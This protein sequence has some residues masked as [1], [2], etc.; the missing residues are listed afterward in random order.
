MSAGD[1]LWA[2]ALHGGAGVKAGRDYGRAEACMAGL[3]ASAGAAL[4]DGAAALDV[5]ETAVAELEASGLFVAGRGAAPNAWGEVELDAGVMDGATRRLGAVAALQGIASPVRTARRLLDIGD[6][7]L[8]VGEGARRFALEEG[9]EATGDLAAWLREPDGFDPAD[10]DEG[11]G[12]VGAVA[13]DRDG[14]LAAATSTGGIYGAAPGRVGDS[15]IAGAG[16]W[17]DD[18]VAVSCTGAG[19]AF[20]RAAAAHALSARVRHGGAT[21]EAAAEAVMAEIARLGGD[22]GLIAV[23]RAGRIVMPFDTPGMK[24]AFVSWVEA[25][26]VG[27]IGAE[28]RAV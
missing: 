8:L 19:E 28:M 14:R 4:R 2:F 13:R 1:A 7:V 27:A 17:A 12:T 15:P 24:R 10:L 21:L 22:G 26:R 5:V 23:D 9:L 3:A 25:L 16:V 6:A 20:L 18:Q 11:H